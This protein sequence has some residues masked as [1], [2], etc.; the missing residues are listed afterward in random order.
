MEGKDAALF[1]W[2]LSDLLPDLKDLSSTTSGQGNLSEYHHNDRD[3]VIKLRPDA[4]LVERELDFLREAA[5]ISVEVK[6]Y[7]RRSQP[8]NKIIGFIMPRLKTVESARMTLDEKVRLFRQIRD[9]ITHLHERHHIIHGDIKLSNILLDGFV[10]RLCDFG[11]SAWMTET[12]FPTEFS[13][14]Y[15]SPYRL[16]SDEANPRPLI[17]E[18]D[19]YA[20]GVAVWEL[21]VGETPLAPYVSDDEEFELWD[22]IVD[23]L[24]VDVDRIEFEEARLYVKECL[25]IERLNIA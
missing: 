17:P 7:V 25:N 3:Y 4:S 20:S 2:R 24:K 23:G 6:G 16:G 9:L 10:A 1:H 8:D 14:R 21:F 11:T 5:D 12:V 22:R 19:V 18:E 15:A 13:I